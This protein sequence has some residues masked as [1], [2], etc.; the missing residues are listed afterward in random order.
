[1]APIGGGSGI[2]A[3][4]DPGKPRRQIDFIARDA[5]SSINSFDRARIAALDGEPGHQRML[6]IEM[7]GVAG[8]PS[9]SMVAIPPGRFLMGSSPEGADD[10]ENEHPQHAVGI[11]YVFALGQHPVTVA[12][13]AAFV[14]DTGHQTG[15][16]SR[17][18]KGEWDWDW[19]WEEGVSWK[20][21]D[22]E[23]SPQHPV[24]C[25]S[26]DD[27]QAFID[28]LNR[29][30]GLASHMNAYRL[31]SEAEWEYACR[32]GTTTRYAFGD[33]ISRSMVNFDDGDADNHNGTTPVGAYPANGF[34][35]HDMHG[36]VWEWCEDTYQETYA[37]AP[38]G[39]T[40]WIEAPFLLELGAAANK[41]PQISK[42]GDRLRVIRGGSWCFG[43]VSVRSAARGAIGNV[44][45]DNDV[46]FRLARTL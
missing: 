25:V 33:D 12:E 8:W 44:N 3:S 11:D 31:P 15:T 43:S 26:W 17:T 20:H 40:A 29:K 9:P 14:A 21:P 41:M 35:L 6:R 38:A 18:S 19:K 23:Q 22:F 13:F 27:A 32:A 5:I 30:T 10:H 2:R 37:G 7:P 46:G 42:I 34:S 39:G 36:N 45:R 28:W 1:L 4:N 16:A 24:C